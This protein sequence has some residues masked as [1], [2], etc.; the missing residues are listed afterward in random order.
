MLVQS[1]KV[2]TIEKNLFCKQVHEA[3]DF[4]GIN[5]CSTYKKVSK[6]PHTINMY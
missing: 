4:L 5:S 6:N 2:A 3:R 1:A